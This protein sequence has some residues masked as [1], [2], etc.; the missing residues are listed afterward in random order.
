VRARGS[1]N[2]GVSIPTF[3]GLIGVVWAWGTEVGKA[4][5]LQPLNCSVEQRRSHLSTI[6]LNCSDGKR[7]CD[8]AEPHEL[9]H[10]LSIP[11]TSWSYLSALIKDFHG[12]S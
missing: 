11:Q 2:L 10:D 3:L 6:H 9:L 12:P 1:E 5:Q 7:S 4:W 8:C